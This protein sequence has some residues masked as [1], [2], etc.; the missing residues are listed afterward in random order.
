MEG[1]VI[2]RIHSL[3]TRLSIIF[4]IFSFLAILLLSLIIGQRAVKQVEQ[5]IGGSLGETAHLMADKLDHYM[6][7]RYGETQILANLNE[8]QHPEKPEKISI[9]INQL[10]DTFPTF[11][12]IGYTDPKGT[13][14]ASSN[15]ILKGVDISERPVY[16]NALEHPFIGD[17]HEAVL[18]ADL[19]PNPSGEEMKFVDI[20]TPV[21]NSDGDLVGVLATH[22]S[23]DWLKE[24]KTSMAET[25]NNRKEVEFFIV[26]PLKSDIVL[27]PEQMLGTELQ[28]PSIELAGQGQNG[29]TREKWA[30]GKEYLTGFVTAAGYE[31]YPGLGWTILVR[32]PV[33]QAYAPVRELMRYFVLTGVILV[34]LSAF[35]G[36]ILAGWM[37]RPLKRI[38]QVADRLRAGENVE[39]PE[40]K[41]ISEI[42]IL[43]DSLQKLVTDLTATES[44]LHMAQN[45]AQHDR[46]TGLP[47][48]YGLDIF[49]EETETEDQ[50]V[51]VL[52]LDL[53]GFKTVNDTYGHAAG[54]Q[55]LKLVAERLQTLISPGELVARI[56][57]DEFVVVLSE[58]RDPVTHGISVGN[59]VIQT[60][61]G[62]FHLKEG[63]VS[64]GCSVGSAVWRA[65]ED[66]IRDIIRQADEALYQA[67]R[68]G[69]NRVVTNDSV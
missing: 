23:W 30:D 53:D 41:G 37:T 55:L 33:E 39:I 15:D 64:V 13:V 2:A 57:G 61:N 62:P 35:V 63:I 32:Q 46:L 7:S 66:N 56:G 52:F 21:K 47:N 14:L 43:S 27:G 20:S 19:L 59:R 24:V 68:T 12:W 40:Y 31:E 26:S 4:V 9:L 36:R 11:S 3:R 67:K 25:L 65:G 58:E 16:K 50:V 69:K 1:F 44:A 60:I 8:L 6:W 38:T 45:K 22:L 18:L 54:D 34:I 17:V 28:T 10:K 48:R 29:W 5:E 51:T 42:E 49:L